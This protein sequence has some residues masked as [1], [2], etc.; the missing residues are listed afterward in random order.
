MQPW[1]QQPFF[2]VALPIVITFALSF[3]YHNRR[4]DDL[5][6]RIE[7]RLSDL[8]KR[9]DDLMK[10]VGNHSLK[11]GLYW[12]SMSMNELNQANDNGSFSFGNTAANPRN[13]G[14]PWANALLGN[15]DSY[16]EASAPVQTIYQPYTREFFA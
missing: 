5:N 4:I 1:R 6:R 12:E 16:S 2:Q 11:F 10:I 14:N 3:W 7:D 8:S 13:A 9:I 15:F